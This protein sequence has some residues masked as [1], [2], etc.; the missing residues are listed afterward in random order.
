M[1][2]VVVLTTV[3][4]I[5]TLILFFIIIVGVIIICPKKEMSVEEPKEE[6]AETVFATRNHNEKKVHQ[7]L[8][9]IT[10][11][12]N[13]KYCIGV[14]GYGIVYKALL[15]LQKKHPPATNQIGW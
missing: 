5:S 3:S 1:D 8:V 2:R 11:N 7:D 10:E 12:L 14:G 15:S 9:K 13:S 6:P 4:I